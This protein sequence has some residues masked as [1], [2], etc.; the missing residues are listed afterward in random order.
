MQFLMGLN[1]SFAQT[2]AQVLMMDPLTPINTI[3]S[4]FVQEERQRNI[5]SGSMS[6]SFEP[7]AF[8][9]KSIGFHNNSTSFHSSN[10]NFTKSRKDKLVCCHFGIAGHIKD[11]CYKL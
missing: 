11:K 8:A 1:E 5:G 4:L 6:S 7:M 9:S 2:R 10:S 3:F